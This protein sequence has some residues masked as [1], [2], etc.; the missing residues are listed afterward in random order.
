M[1]ATTEQT[2]LVPRIKVAGADVTG[3]LAGLA[4]LAVSVLVLQLFG[5]KQVFPEAITSRFPFVE[6]VNEAEDWLK[7]NLRWLTRAISDSVGWALDTLEEFLWTTPWIVVLIALVMPA[8]AYGGLRLALLTTFGVMMWGAFGMW[9]E[10]MSTLSMMGVAVALCVVIGVGLGVLCAQSDRV[11]SFIRP[12][13]DTMQVMPAFVYLMPAIFFFGI[14]A[15][16]ATMAVMIYALPPMIRLTNLGLRQVPSTMIEAGR[17]F[18]ATRAQMLFKV[19]IPQAMPSIML[20]VN[21]TIMMALALAVLAP[22]VGGG[23]LGAEVWRAI[24]KLKVGWSLEGGLCIVGMAIIFDRLSQAM[25]RPRALSVLGPGEMRFRLLP[26]HWD[27][28]ALAR[29]IETPIDLV[30]SSVGKAVMRVVETIG[31]AFDAV[32][33][34]GNVL[35][36]GVRNRPYLVC[37][38][39]L[40]AVC[41]LIETYAPRGWR[42]GAYPG[43]LEFSIRETVDHVIQWLTVNPTFIAITKAIRAVTYLYFLKPLD[44]FLTHLPWWY[45][46]AVFSGL[47]WLGAG[48][49][50]ALATFLALLFCGAAGLWSDT[51]YTMAGTLVSVGVC[52]VIGIPIGIL[53]AHSRPM[54]TAVRPVLDLM[55]T[56]PTFVYLI[57][58]LFFFGG[59][60][61]TGIIATV[62]YAIPPIIRTTILGLQQ[63]PAEI[64][65][66]SRSFG[67]RT[68]QSLAKIKLPLASP[69]IL[70]GVNQ[71]FIMALAMQT[72]TPLIGGLG[73]GKEVYDAMNRSNTGAG[74][75]A[76]IGIAL[77]AIVLDRVTH[78]M[79]AKQRAAL[80]IN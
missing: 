24:T 31:R 19:E 73:L 33:A 59:N 71:T 25:S 75:A 51:M 4:I 13:L 65:E 9:Y 27:K 5:A 64:E 3:V 48:W 58:A 37:G 30:W 7:D 14:G 8:L 55:Q 6:W 16:S 41:L 36:D 32:P 47:V 21:Q 62:V 12:V 53:A 61:T 39:V 46:M 52:L 45:V 2:P 10:A 35:A 38:V 50:L 49:R 18:G 29:A 78:A 70:L 69:S 68:W 42:I 57:P 44:Q 28:Y 54:E 77:M 56:I 22:F 79:T 1:T 66:V 20:G 76:G 72:V 11:E 26:Q 67:A 80:G 15:T 17:S 60:P 74:L 43:A 40:I 23:G 63:V 34:I